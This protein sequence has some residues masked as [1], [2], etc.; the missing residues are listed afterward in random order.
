MVFGSSHANRVSR[1]AEEIPSELIQEVRPEQPKRTPIRNT[2]QEPRT[3][4]T[5]TEPALLRQQK[6]ASS[7]AP[8]FRPGDR[9]RHKIF[10][11]GTIIKVTPMG[12]DALLEVEFDTKGLKKIMANYAGLQKL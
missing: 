11:D 1:F 12:N 8:E 2:Q 9:V 10:K 5:Q 4:V 6:I 7:K 3:H